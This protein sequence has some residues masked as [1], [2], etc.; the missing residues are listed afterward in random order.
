LPMTGRSR[1]RR[2]DPQS[3][4][5]F[6]FDLGDAGFHHLFDKRI[7]ERLVRGKLD[8][9]FG[10]GVALQLV[11]KLFD[12]RGG[13]EQAAMVREGRE[14]DEHAFVLD[15]GNFVADDFA[16]FGRSG[17]ANGRANRIQSGAGGL[18]DAGKILVN[19]FWSR[20]LGRTLGFRR[21]FAMAGFGFLHGAML[22]KAGDTVH[23]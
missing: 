8:G 2:G 3:A 16:G 23:A 19:R 13:G 4:A 6:G 1:K 15:G 14:P 9:S 12:D 17:G 11:L 21:R 20:A 5:G 18:G 7:R 22:S 10:E